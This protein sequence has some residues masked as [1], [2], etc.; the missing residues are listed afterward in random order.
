LSMLVAMGLSR[1]ADGGWSKLEN[2]RHRPVHGMVSA[3]M[4]LSVFL[5]Q[6]CR[7]R[8]ALPTST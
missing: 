5:R 7:E 4:M 1:R 2:T 3:T 6:H 8:T